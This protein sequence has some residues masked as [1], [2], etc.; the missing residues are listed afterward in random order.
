MKNNQNAGKTSRRGFLKTLGAATGA[1]VIGHGGLIDFGTANA[2]EQPKKTRSDSSLITKKIP[3]T[4]ESVSAIGLGSFLTFD[5]LP[6][7]PREF[8]GEVVKRFYEGGGRV[9]DTSPLYGTAETSV[10]QAINALG[11]TTDLFIANKIW[12]TGDY[13]ADDSLARKSFEQSQNRL[14]REKF[15]VM[16]VH[17]LVNADVVVPLLNRWKQEGLVRYVAVTHHETAYF[18][19][20]ANWVE[21]GVIDFVQVRYSVATRAAEERLFPAAIEKGVAVLVNMPLEKGRLHQLVANRPLPDF[22]KDFGAENWAQVF[23]KWAISHPAVTCAIPATSN[24]QHQTEN[25]G[26]L[27]G[28]LPDRK[29]RER[30]IKYMES[31]PGFTNL[32]TTAW[33]PGKNYNGII[34]RAQQKNQAK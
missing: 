4:G 22:V 32:E 11:I 34:K 15:E 20:L 28:D 5:V 12:S 3:R 17:S 27:K 33:Y 10:G 21:K 8:V 26:A 23:L 29:M 16:Q 1:A 2:Q 9:L 13:L 31:I 6:G 14:W 7:Q 30:I 18:P 24:P 25:I 19:A